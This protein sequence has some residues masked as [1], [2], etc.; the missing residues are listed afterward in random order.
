MSRL[1]VL[2]RSTRCYWYYGIILFWLHCYIEPIWHATGDYPATVLMV[3]IKAAAKARAKAERAG[4]VYEEKG[5]KWET[6][7]VKSTQGFP[8]W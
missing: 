3:V 4:K 2:A 5:E 7:G 8:K 1:Q 6:L